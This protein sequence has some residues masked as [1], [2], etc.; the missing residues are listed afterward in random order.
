MEC[1]NLSHELELPGDER[2]AGLVEYSRK[3]DVL[4]CGGGV[5]GVAAARG[6]RGEDSDAPGQGRHLISL[7]SDKYMT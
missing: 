3:F 1:K 6:S 7:D 2:N 4:V 5:A